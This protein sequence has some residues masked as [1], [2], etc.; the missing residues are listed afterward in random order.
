MKKQPPKPKANIALPIKGGTATPSSPSFRAWLIFIYARVKRVARWIA[1][2][3]SFAPLLLIIPKVK[4]EASVN[5]NPKD[6]LATQFAVTNEGFLPVFDVVFNCIPKTDGMMKMINVGANHPSISI[7]WPSRTAT[8]N[9]RI[10]VE[11][12]P[13]NAAVEI[14][15]NYRWPVYV[16]SSTARAHFTSRKGAAGYFLVPDVD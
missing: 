10:G 16:I 15:V 12:E 14:A 5:L 4:I 13:A 7:L 2:A 9:C 1:L 8:R 3:S 11:L 6:L